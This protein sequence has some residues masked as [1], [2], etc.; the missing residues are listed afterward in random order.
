MLSTTAGVSYRGT[1]SVRT[2][3][4]QRKVC[5]YIREWSAAGAIVGMQSSCVT[6]KRAWQA[7]APVAYKT[8]QS[9]GSLELF[10]MQPGAAVA[11]ASFEVDGLAL[12][13]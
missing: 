4:A 2:D 3:G 1:G 13:R 11:G 5:L 12:T 7:F 8:A 6:A 9:G 10:V